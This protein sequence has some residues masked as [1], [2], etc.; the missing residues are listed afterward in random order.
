MANS[1]EMIATAFPGQHLR[2]SGLFSCRL[3]G[4]E[5]SSGLHPAPDDHYSLFDV[6]SKRICSLDSSAFSTLEVSDDNLPNLNPLIYLLT[7]HTV[8]PIS[9]TMSLLAIQN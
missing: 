9:Y 7:L 1:K 3:H 5:V 4:L 6:Y 8:R 2:L